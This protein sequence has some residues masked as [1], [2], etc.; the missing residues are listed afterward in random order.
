MRFFKSYQTILLCVTKIDQ[1]SFFF[2]FPCKIFVQ[3]DLKNCFI[4]LK[5][6]KKFNFLEKNDFSGVL[7]DYFISFD[8]SLLKRK[9]IFKIFKMSKVAKGIFFP[10]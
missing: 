2:N 5:F 1:L 6:Q 7:F 9:T 4:P 10:L 8:L 3:S